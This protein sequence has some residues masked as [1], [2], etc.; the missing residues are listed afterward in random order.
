MCGGDK[1][2][3]TR[4]L[5]LSNKEPLVVVKARIDIVWEVIREDCSNGR[6]GVVRKGEAPLRRGRCGGVR[7]GTLGAENRDISCDWSSDVH[8][9]SKVFTMGRGDKDVVGVNSNVLV[10]RSEEESVEDFL[11]DLGGSGRHCWRVRSIYDS[12]L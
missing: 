9:G 6:G 7:K 4:V 11:G 2:R 8:W 10:K 5:S 3:A 12:L 1:D